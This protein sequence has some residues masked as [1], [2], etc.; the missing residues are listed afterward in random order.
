ML[1]VFAGKRA[2]QHVRKNGLQPP[3]VNRVMG[4]SGAAKWLAIAGLD[5]AIFGR[6]LNES[7]HEVTLFGTSVGAFKLAAAAHLDPGAALDRLATAY[8]E[9]RYGDKLNADSIAEQM[10]PVLDAVAGN[11]A[12]EQIL[13]N[14]RLR[15]Q[16]GAVRCVD[17]QLA[18]ESGRSQ[19]IGLARAFA[20]NL[21]GRSHLAR[22]V[23]RTVFT[24]P[25]SAN[26]L[27]GGNSFSTQVVELN[28]DNYRPALLASGSLPV[29]MQAVSKIQGATAGAYRD[30]GLLDYHPLPVVESHEGQ[31]A[32]NLVLYPHFYSNLTEGWFDKFLSWR[33]VD[34]NRLD[35]VILLAPS[36][37]H[38]SSLQGQAIPDRRDFKTFQG[39][40][41][42][43][44]QRWRS[45]VASSEQ[46]GELFLEWAQS[47]EIAERMQPI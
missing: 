42:E 15:L 14:P 6:W 35:D 17:K 41:E 46:L 16:F 4:A 3:D 24:D 7:N 30:G 18:C 32:P 9:Q 40:D 34:P 29:Y 25:R 19:Q 39:Q 36:A 33:T 22:Y 27:V 20:A 21:R 26:P 2:Y 11:G 23:Q 5:K 44:I 43:R 8:I 31:A 37:A 10:L 28:M 12:V 47:G 45:A 38:V 13:S 1:S